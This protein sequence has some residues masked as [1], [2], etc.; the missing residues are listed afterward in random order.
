MSR[1][2][3]YAPEQVITVLGSNISVSWSVI[4]LGL[5]RCQYASTEVLVGQ[6]NKLFNSSIVSPRR[7]IT[8]E[9]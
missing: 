7:P 9:Q 5:L 8:T 1:R 4:G 3:K 6:I 2:S